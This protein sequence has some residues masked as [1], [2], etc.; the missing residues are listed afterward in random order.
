VEGMGPDYT[1]GRCR[2]DQRHIAVVCALGPGIS[3]VDLVV[4]G[5][6]RPCSM[7]GGVL[8]TLNRRF[9]SK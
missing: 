9:L 4:L 3:A 1:A 7:I 5:I 8:M 6:Y 2:L